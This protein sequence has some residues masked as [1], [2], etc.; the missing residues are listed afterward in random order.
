MFCKLARSSMMNEEVGC[1]PPSL[2][3]KRRR[4]RR[5]SQLLVPAQSLFV[6]EL[7]DS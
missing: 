2:L 4:R 1:S 5:Y 6:F 3:K 7:E